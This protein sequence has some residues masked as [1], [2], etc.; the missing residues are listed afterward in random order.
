MRRRSRNL[1][2]NAKVTLHLD[3]EQEA[4]DGGVLSIEGVMCAEGITPEEAFAEYS[5]LTRVM[6]ARVRA[7]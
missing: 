6:P 7:Y 2:G 4:E 5:T 3:T 1:Q